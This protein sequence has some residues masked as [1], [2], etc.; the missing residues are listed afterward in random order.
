MIVETAFTTGRCESCG[1]TIAQ[2][3]NTAALE[4]EQVLHQLHDFGDPDELVPP[5]R[6]RVC[7][8]CL[9]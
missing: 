5:A 7:A 6:F 9:P 1:D 3:G 4:R 2:A 8:G